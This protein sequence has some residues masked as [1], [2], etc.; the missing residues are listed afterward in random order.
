[1]GK[2]INEKIHMKYVDYPICFK[3]RILLDTIIHFPESQ[4]HSQTSSV[5]RDIGEFCVQ[6]IWRNSTVRINW[7]HWAF[8]DQISVVGCRLAVI[9][10]HVGCIIRSVRAYHLIC[11]HGK[12]PLVYLLFLSV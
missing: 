4:C 2:L 3:P 1:M 7:A 11:Q 10:M 9:C 5:Y 8:A 6:S 12:L